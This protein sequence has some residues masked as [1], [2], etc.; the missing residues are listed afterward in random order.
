MDMEQKGREM[1]LTSR[2]ATEQK[3]STRTKQR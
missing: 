1:K 2:K 3:G